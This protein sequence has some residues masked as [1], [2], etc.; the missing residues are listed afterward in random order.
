MENSECS[1]K[2]GISVDHLHLLAVMFSN[3]STT[4]YRIRHGQLCDISEFISKIFEYTRLQY[5]INTK[6]LS[7]ENHHYNISSKVDRYSCARVIMN[8]INNLYHLIFA[9]K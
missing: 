9:Q 4:Q 2:K 6:W 7:A 5:L 3:E 1:F 8:V